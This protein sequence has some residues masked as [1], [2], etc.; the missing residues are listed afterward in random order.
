MKSSSIP[1]R[2]S[3]SEMY[4]HYAGYL[5]HQVRVCKQLLQSWGMD[6]R[7]TRF[8]LHSHGQ[9][10]DFKLGI[11]FAIDPD[12]ERV[13]RYGDEEFHFDGVIPQELLQ[14]CHTS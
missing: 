6:P 7:K 4:I 2:H 8:G 1:G 12:L 5:K 11:Q 13:A 10:F 14:V 3:Q 9:Y